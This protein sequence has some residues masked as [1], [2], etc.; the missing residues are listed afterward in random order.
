MSEWINFVKALQKKRG[1]SFKDALVAASKLY[2]KKG[3]AKGKAKGKAKK[4]N[5]AAAPVKKKRRKR[6]RTAE[7]K[8]E[9]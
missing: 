1:I 7:Q 3:A 4:S 2:K 8:A 9:E 6:K 5:G